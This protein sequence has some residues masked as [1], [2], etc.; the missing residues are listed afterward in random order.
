MSDQNPLFILGPTDIPDQL[1]QAMDVQTR[2][3][4]APDFID[5]M[6]RVQASVKEVFVTES[7]HILFF[8]SSRTGGWEAAVTNTLSA[9]DKVLMARNGV[10]SHRWIDRCQRHGAVWLCDDGNGDGRSGLS[11]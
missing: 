5:L 9:G 10:F 4:R 7:G 11:R 2:D 3:H 1:L 6:Q 8:P